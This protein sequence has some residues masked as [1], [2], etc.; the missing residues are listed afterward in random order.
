MTRVQA[1]AYTPLTAGSAAYSPQA[2]RSYHKAAM[3][4]AESAAFFQIHA[5][6]NR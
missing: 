3:A 5:D 4:A 1:R 2:S 6:F